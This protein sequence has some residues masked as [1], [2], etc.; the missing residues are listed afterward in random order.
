MKTWAIMIA[1]GLGT[2]LIRYSMIGLSGKVNLPG[3]LVKAT[4][5]IPASMLSALVASQMLAYTHPEQPASSVPYLGA[6]LIAGI[7]A[8]KTRN[9]FLT[10]LVGMILLWLLRAAPGR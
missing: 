5:F 3:V 10:V 2:F 8:W 4:R 6:S 7:V 9:A 1:L